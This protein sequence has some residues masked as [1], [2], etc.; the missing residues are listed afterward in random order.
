MGILDDIATAVGNGFIQ[1]S[2][3]ND[4]M[5]SEAFGFEPQPQ[6]QAMSQ[7]ITTDLEN[8]VEKARQQREI[9]A[10]QEAEKKRQQEEWNNSVLGKAEHWD[11]LEKATP[12]GNVTS[13]EI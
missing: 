12:W 9:A 11:N 13:Y 6:L 2:A 7:A 10:K 8:K 3:N 4:A 5:Y 1:N